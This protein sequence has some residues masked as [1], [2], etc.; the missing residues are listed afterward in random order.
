MAPT[1]EFDIDIPEIESGQT[2]LVGLASPGMAGLTAVNQVVKSVESREIGYISPTDLPGITP[3]EDGTPRHHTRLYDLVGTDVI[4]LVGELFVPAWAAR[5]FGDSLLQ[6]SREGEVSEIAFLHTV[7]YPHGP[8]DHQVFHVATD[9]Y[10]DRRL[11]GQSTPMKG[12]VLDGVA[13][14]VVNASLGAGDPPVGVFITPAHPPGPD[15]DGALLFLDA[16]EDIYD[17]SVDRS[18]LE[19][20]S[21]EIKQ[22]YETLD[23]RLAT[24]NEADEGRDERDFYA[25]R[26]YM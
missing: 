1:T 11:T 15:V 21:R 18:E 16:I 22:Y 3:F 26:M 5:S 19:E 24:I 9:A 6:W 23:E 10:R 8:D 2:L 20:L 17:I 12:G 4:V 14:E 7:A 13:G 25:D